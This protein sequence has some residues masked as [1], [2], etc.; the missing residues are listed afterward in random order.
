MRDARFSENTRF[1]SRL[2]GDAEESGC[3]SYGPEWVTSWWWGHAREGLERDG[4]IDDEWFCVIV[5]S[6]ICIVLDSDQQAQA[7]DRGN[8][9]T[10]R[11][12]NK[13]MILAIYKVFDYSGA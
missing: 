13:C 8:K 1:V 2:A 10:C 7:K 4:G 12:L 5:L 9:S 3:L 11:A 6:S